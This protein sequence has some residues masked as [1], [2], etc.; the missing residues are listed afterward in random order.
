MQRK[1]GRS[2]IKVVTI[3]RDNPAGGGMSPVHYYRAYLPLKALS[4]ICKKEF[5]ISFLKREQLE[6]LLGFSKNMESWLLDHDIFYISRL[7]HTAGLDTF[8]KTVH[9]T[10]GK[11]IFDTDDDLTDDFR[12][13][14][15]GEDFKTT[16]GRMD[17]VV[18]STPYLADRIA[19]YVGY[20]PEVC[21]N[22]IDVKWFSRVSTTA[23]RIV[24]GLSVGFVGTASH[25]GDWRYPVEA[26][27]RLAKERKDITITVAGYCP[28]YLEDLPNTHKI[29]SVTYTHYPAVVRQFDI[30]CCSLDTEDVFNYS[31]SSVKALEAMAARRKLPCGGV[32]GAIPVC[33]D[34]TLYR[35][36][37]NHGHNGLLTD[38]DSWY[39]TLSSLI[40]DKA[41]M[42]KLSIQGYAWVK[43]NRNMETGYRSWRKVIK[44][45]HG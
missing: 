35:R 40:D 9:N 25:Y 26:L 38:N 44:K 14:G 21:Y 29:P 7:Y 12:D 1:Q 34:M 32:G 31:K 37:V 42:R 23:S 3:L 28:D 27:V 19:P 22:H 2:L 39:E 18:C 11:V 36:T 15:R 6:K 20:R 4:E 24:K 13:L 43:K 30:I 41:L 16:L 17:Q 8:V 5:S 45:V 10:G 33:T